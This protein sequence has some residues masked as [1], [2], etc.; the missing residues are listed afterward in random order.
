VSLTQPANAGDVLKALPLYYNDTL[1]QVRAKAYLL[2]RS[3]GLKAK[4]S[5]VRQLAVMQ[6]VNACKDKDSGNTG[7]LFGYLTKFKKEDFNSKAKDSLSSL[8]RRKPSHYDQLLRLAG[9]L[10][11]KNVTTE[12]RLATQPQ[13]NVP[14]KRDRWAAELAL[15]R[16]GDEATVTSI[17]QRVKKL[18]VNNDVVYDV[19]P[20]LVY[21]RQQ[22][23][24]DYMIVVL[25]DDS[26]NCLSAD[27]E[28]EAAI[29][30]AYRVM[31]Q[32]APAIKDYP[33]EIDDSGDVKTKD[34]PKA[35]AIVRT[36]FKQQKAYKVNK[37]TY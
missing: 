14:G 28:R 31:E 25:N 4:K 10:D 19:F 7:Q 13:P 18:G 5:S 32:L 35:L 17:L 1:K 11:L 16:M 29:P 27:A 30:C 36:W 6:L 8:V 26:K 12:I 9:F 23:L 15:A 37:E 24:L 3:I 21:T 33:L 22:P 2:G 20:D 34:Y